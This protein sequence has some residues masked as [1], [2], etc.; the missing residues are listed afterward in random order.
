MLLSLWDVSKEI[1]ASH[2]PST[3]PPTVEELYERLIEKNIP[4][5]LRCGL[6]AWLLTSDFFEY[7]LC[8]TP[9]I[10]DLAIHGSKVGASGP[11]TIRKVASDCKAIQGREL[12][13][14]DL[15]HALCKISRQNTRAKSGK[16]KSASSK[17]DNLGLERDV[18]SVTSGPTTTSGSKRQKRRK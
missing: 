6:I 9:T 15:E 1:I 3:T 11:K 13:V 17:R 4:T 2:K 12:S 18:E 8:Q 14:V 5:I 7:G 10:K 16:G